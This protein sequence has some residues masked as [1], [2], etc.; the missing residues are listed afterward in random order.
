V[1]TSADVGLAVITSESSI[2]SGLRRIDMTVGE[3][4]DHLV[5]RQMGVLQELA[6]EL[7]VQPGQV[8]GRVADLRRA[9]RDAEREIERLRDEVR[10]A[11]VRGSNGGPRRRQASV[12]LIL[13]QVPAGGRDDLRGW[14]DRYLEALGGS[15]IVAVVDESNFVVKVS[16]DLAGAHP[17]TGLASLLGRGGGRPELAQGRL[18]K[19]VADAFNEV[20]ASLQ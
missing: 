3:S 8:P 7:G 9:A 13:E 16:K 15:G 6:R 18:T 12:P 4:A 19:P 5:R 17:A 2:G 14:A 10:L 1:D 11:H 20:E